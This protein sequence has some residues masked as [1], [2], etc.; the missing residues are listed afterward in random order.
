MP[1]VI[2]IKLLKLSSIKFTYSA[3]EY[4]V[5][6]IDWLNSTDFYLLLF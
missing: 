1:S 3:L 4:F 2:S 5:S 6:L